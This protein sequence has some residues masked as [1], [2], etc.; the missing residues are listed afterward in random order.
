M[1]GLETGRILS[2]GECMVE[3]APGADG[4]FSMG[5]AG[6]TLNTAWYLRRNLPAGWAVD[7]LSAVGRDPISDRMLAFFD[8]AGLGTAH[9]ARIEGRT[10]GLYL[11][12]L[13]AGERSF[14][15]WRD[16]SAARLLAGDAGRLAAALAGARVAYLSGI[17]L[18]ILPGADRER[19]MQA[20]AVARAAGTR[21]VF[22]PNLRPRLWP[23]RGAM[24]DAVSAMAAAAE[25]VLP[26]FDDE[27]AAFGD[28]DPMA[29][30]RRYAALGAGLVVVKNGAGEI[31]VWSDR[32]L[33]RW[34]PPE[35]AEVVDSTAA[36]DSFNAAFLAAH[37]QGALLEAAL[38]AGA[39]LAGRVIGQRGALV[40]V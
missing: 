23:D 17:T 24:C 10:V 33:T 39:E 9:V 15:Y 22:D 32:R 19:L 6:D 13:Q 27:A 3:M 34:Q 8:G 2:I 36:G 5:F 12:Q 38:T 20:L 26:S 25:V 28:A 40:A 18:A 31:A 1:T 37:L 11:I 4:R 30:A 7:Y 29:T 16:T 14:A 21:V 35:V